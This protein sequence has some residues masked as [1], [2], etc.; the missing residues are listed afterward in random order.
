MDVNGGTKVG[1]REN[2]GD[3]RE[4]ESGVTAN[5]TNKGST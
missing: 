5:A 2:Q 1:T 3:Q 4:D